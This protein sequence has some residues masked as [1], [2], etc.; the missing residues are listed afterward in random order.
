MHLDW[1]KLNPT[2]SVL[3][4]LEDAHPH[5]SAEFTP[6]LQTDLLQAF[7]TDSGV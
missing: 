5:L 4:V 7:R 1:E 2:V 6:V 3:I